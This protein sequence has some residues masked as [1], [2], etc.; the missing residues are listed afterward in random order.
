[1]AS[2]NK[3]ILIGNLGA[4]PELRTTAGGQAVC[5]LRLATN[6]RWTDKSGATQERTEWHRVVVWGRSA[7]NAAKYLAKGRSAY[8]EGRLQTREWTD[9]DG[10]K[11][12]TTE[13]VADRLQF[14]GGRD[15]GGG[16]GRYDGPPPPRD[17]DAPSGGDTSFSDDE[18]PF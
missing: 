6:E 7:E 17:D 18:I 10:N 15:G 4:D 5:E 9:K 1:M 8:V 16:G 12:Y 2:V 11:R 14:I 3:V 13:I